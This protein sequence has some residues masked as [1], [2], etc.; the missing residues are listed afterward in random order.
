MKELGK[1][2]SENRTNV[3]FA[4]LDTDLVNALI[5]TEDA[6]FYEH[7]GVDIKALLRAVVGVF[8]GGSGGGGSTIT[9]QLAKMMY[10]RGE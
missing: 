4:Q 8:G 6:R 5:A 2:Y 1:Y 9:Q 7:S 3:R 10:P